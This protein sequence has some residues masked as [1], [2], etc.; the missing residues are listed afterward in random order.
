MLA[1]LLPRG[2]ASPPSQVL[3]L[4][5][6]VGVLNQPTPGREG[7]LLYSPHQNFIDAVAAVA[8]ESKLSRLRQAIIDRGVE[9]HLETDGTWQVRPMPVAVVADT[10]RRLDA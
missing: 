2:L 10:Q 4:L 3:A 8:E 7:A 6:H 1:P 5:A 9:L